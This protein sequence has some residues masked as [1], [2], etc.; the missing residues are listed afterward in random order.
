MDLNITQAPLPV[1]DPNNQSVNGGQEITNIKKLQVGVGD[2]VFLVD[3]EA[4]KWGGMTKIAAK[5]VINYDG[6]AVFKSS[7]GATLINSGATD[8]NFVNIVNTALNSATKTILSDF[9]FQATDYAGAFKAGNPTWD[10]ITGLIT[11]GSGVLINAR[12]ILGANAGVPTFTLDATTG[13]ATFAG[14][15]SAPSGTL[16]TITAGTITGATIQTASSGYRVRL[17][18]SNKV[19]FLLDNTS[20]G[21]IYADAA[22]TIIYNSANNHHFFSGSSDA[23]V[24]NANGLNL[25]SGKKLSF[26]GGGSIVDEGSQLHIT[27][28]A[29]G[30]MSLKIEGNCYPNSDNA[31]T[32][33]ASNKYWST[34]YG[35]TIRC[36]TTF[37][38]SDGSS[39][40]TTGS[41]DFVTL[42][43]YN[44]TDG[45]YR[46]TRS[47]NFK[48]GI[49][50]G[51]GN[52]S[53]NIPW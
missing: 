2:V 38:S 9:T 11:G 40:V 42:V 21:G 5:A 25:A 41:F 27:G 43:A 19:E 7:T 44:S 49:L 8:G 39:G 35:K 34:I 37:Q 10:E 20:K 46:R 22:D 17:S 23:G 51:Y 31:Y 30:D 32:L 24:L 18:N 26:S 6:T 45:N 52:E 1:Y 12:G 15:L 4:T 36:G 14:T 3:Q 29:G 47:L 28:A 50:V 13:N 48:N 53:G 33:G 16:G